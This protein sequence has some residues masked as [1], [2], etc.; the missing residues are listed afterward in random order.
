MAL[1]VSSAKQRKTSVKLTPKILP[2][3]WKKILAPEFKRSYFSDLKKFIQGEYAAGKT[4]YPARRDMF[5]ALEFLDY[6]DV[7]VVILGQDPYHGEKQ[8][9]GL[10]FAVPNELMP[11]PPS[12]MNVFKEIQSDLGVTLSRNNSDLSG[13]VAQGV[14]LLNAVLTVRASEAFSHRFRGGQGWEYFTDRIISALNERK[15]PV[16]FLLW[17][18]AAQKKKTLI[19]NPQ[20]FILEAVHPSPLS[21]SRGFFGCKHFSKTNKI[22]RSLKKQPIDWSMTTFTSIK[23]S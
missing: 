10:A 5:R 11:K 6:P 14:L 22:L 18:S 20:H 17:G 9:I 2:P 1:R 12:L 4:V 19:T 8:A 23:M 15:D 13:W 16:I 3:G 7:K 21:A